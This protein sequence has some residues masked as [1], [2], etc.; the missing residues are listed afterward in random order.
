MDGDERGRAVDEIDRRFEPPQ[1][2]ARHDGA[3]LV[4]PPEMRR[5]VGAYA[6][7]LRFGDVMQKG[8]PAQHPRAAGVLPAQIQRLHRHRRVLP[9]VVAMPA[10]GLGAAHAGQH[11]RHGAGQ[12][13][14]VLRQH[15]PRAGGHQ[16]AVQLCIEAL[17][18]DALQ[19]LAG[20]LGRGGRGIVQAEAQPRR[21]AQRAQ[22]AQRVL[23]KAG[24]GVADAA[25]DARR[26]V[27]AAAVEVNDAL[28]GGV[29]HGVDGKIAPGQVVGQRADK[30]DLVGVAVVAVGA[31]LAV[32]RD[33]IHFAVQHHAHGAVLDAGE[34]QL[35]AGKQG[36]RFFRPGR[37]AEVPVAGGAPQQA[38]AHAAAHHIGAVARGA[39]RL[40]QPQGVLRQPDAL[41][42]HAGLLFLGL[43]VKRGAIPA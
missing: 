38:V 30:M 16:Q 39:Q 14:A 23:A 5:T 20:G 9:H 42:P 36:A 24:R 15:I 13:F 19:R 21:K 12:N 28:A 29:G 34:H 10:P 22:D 40:Q 26:Q 7:A 31:V 3:A 41:L 11:F 33:L 37:G 35:L 32:G 25:H 17:G 1:N 4:V 43:A 2:R 18:A 27:A 6:A 8:G